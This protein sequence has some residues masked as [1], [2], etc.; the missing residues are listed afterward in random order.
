MVIHPDRIYI[1]YHISHIISLLQMSQ[2]KLKYKKLLR[3]CSKMLSDSVKRKG[4]KKPKMVET[5]I[6]KTHNLGH[7]IETKPKMVEIK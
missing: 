5:K 3:T 7:K 1:Y 4:G 2:N 6:D